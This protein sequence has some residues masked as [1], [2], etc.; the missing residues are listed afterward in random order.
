MDL[1]AA[2]RAS[3]VPPSPGEAGSIS[4]PAPVDEPLPTALGGSAGVF[5]PYRGSPGPLLRV[6]WMSAPSP[7]I[8]G[9]RIG[10]EGEYRAYTTEIHGV[11]ATPVHSLSAL[12]RVEYE[13]PGVG[14]LRPY[15][16]AGV[17]GGIHVMRANH[18]I[19]ARRRRGDPDPDVDAVGTSSGGVLVVGTRLEIAKSWRLS[20][21]ARASAEFQWTRALGLG[22]GY[23]GFPLKTISGAEVTVGFE[24]SF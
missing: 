24:Y 12:A 11:D 20:A 3:A 17:I 22:V 19:R 23:D 5:I 16:G 10:A 9:L 18:V 15:V 1:A 6:Q 21:E 8:P 13:I 4:G 2:R 14:A 7:E